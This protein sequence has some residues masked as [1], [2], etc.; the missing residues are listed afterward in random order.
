LL[1]SA[2]PGEVIIM[3]ESYT[4]PVYDLSPRVKAFSG[5][6]TDDVLREIMNVESLDNKERSKLVKKSYDAIDNKNITGLKNAIDELR[7]ICHPNDTLVT[8]LTLELVS[9]QALNG[10]VRMYAG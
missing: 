6:L 8:E 4:E 9:L 1:A 5:W 7:Q 3:P 10:S 2:G